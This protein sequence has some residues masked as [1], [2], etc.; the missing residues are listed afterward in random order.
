MTNLMTVSRQWA[1]R[2]DDERHETLDSLQFAVDHRRQL[3]HEVEKLDFA[4]LSLAFD[5]DD[6]LYLSGHNGAPVRFT[7]WSFGQFAGLL[8]SRASYL[9]ELPAPLAKLL[10]EY[11]LEKTASGRQQAKLLYTYED[12]EGQARAFTSTNYGRIWDA[13]VVRA[14]QHINQDGRWHVPLKAYGGINSKRATTLYA[15]DRDV[16]VFL[17]DEARPI[18]IGDQ[19]YFRGFYTW[20]SETRA[21]TFG[22]ATFLYSYVCANRIIWGARDIQELRI[23]HTKLAPD[24]FLQ[25][26]APALA[27]LSDASDRP[28]RESI[29]AAQNRKLGN[30]TKEV[31][32]W[33]YSKGFGRPVARE[34]IEMAQDP[35][36]GN[37]GDPLSLWGV[38]QGGT[39]AARDIPHT[40]ARIER[41][42]KWSALL[43]GQR[44]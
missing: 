25:K 44:N 11:H 16:F 34:A 3:S 31:E 15:S 41:E 14:V 43:P 19:T 29:E 35:A 2:P 13:Q 6:D 20:N 21:A 24:R 1:S 40:D 23:R 33:L 10:L 28:I 5:G 27:A 18:E 42:Q 8:G 26:A 32:D 22:L 4:T 12:G 38:V 7:N 17:V 36:S 37:S 39:A 30:S 9:R